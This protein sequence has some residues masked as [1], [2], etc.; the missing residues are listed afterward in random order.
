MGHDLLRMSVLNSNSDGMH[1][2]G[3]KPSPEIGG[4]SLGWVAR[5]MRPRRRAS[6]KAI[7]V[8]IWD[9]LSSMCKINC[10]SDQLGDKCKMGGFIR[11]FMNLGGHTSEFCIFVMY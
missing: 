2:I 11:T 6:E 1:R 9:D 8:M 3:S 4:S 7:S 5:R 10:R